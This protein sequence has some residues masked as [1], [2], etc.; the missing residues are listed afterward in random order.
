MS[1][2]AF[3]IVFVTVCIVFSAWVAA[4]GLREYNASHSSGA[5]ALSILFLTTA[6]V[7]VWYGVRVSRKLRELP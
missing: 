7:L 2:R 5:L 1:L 4:W 3:H 6:F